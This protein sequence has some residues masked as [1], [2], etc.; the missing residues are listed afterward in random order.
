MTTKTVFTMLGACLLVF[1]SP[2]GQAFGEGP[3]AQVTMPVMPQAITSSRSGSSVGKSLGCSSG[4]PEIQATPPPSGEEE[5]GQ[6]QSLRKRAEEG[7]PQAQFDLGVMYEKG[8]GVHRDDAQAR[9]WWEKS[10]VAGNAS[11]QLNLGYIYYHGEGVPQDLVCA[12]KWYSM[13]AEQGVAEAQ[14]TLAEMYEKGLGNAAPDS[15]LANKGND[16]S[17]PVSSPD[18]VKAAEWFLK[19][20]EQGDAKAQ[21]IL[22]G[23][24]EKGYGVRQDI[25]KARDWHGKACRN[26]LRDACEAYRRIVQRDW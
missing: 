4:E 14:F 24:Y 26:G 25:N 20:A 1:A 22:G 10:A 19:A 9:W 21:H 8:D 3:A 13:A 2:A 6:A 11:A 16:P 17:N 12:R 7:D 15:A 23:M 18:M 5:G